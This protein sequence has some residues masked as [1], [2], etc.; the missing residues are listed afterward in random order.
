M[1]LRKQT[2]TEMNVEF[3]LLA[4]L[5]V[6]KSFVSN[7]EV[8]CVLSASKKLLASRLSKVNPRPFIVLDNCMWVQ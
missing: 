7:P 2:S 1:V 5:G 6:I 3:G 4:V 8:L